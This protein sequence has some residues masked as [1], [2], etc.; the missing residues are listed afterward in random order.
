M[1]EERIDDDDDDE[2]DDDDHDHDDDHD[3]DSD[4]GCEVGVGVRYDEKAREALRLGI[5]EGGWYCLGDY[6]RR[7]LSP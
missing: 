4:D 7:I 3:G 6:L 5:G 1:S 2:D